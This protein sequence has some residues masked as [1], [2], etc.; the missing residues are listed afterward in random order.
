MWETIIWWEFR[1][2]PYNIIV[3]L[4]GIVTSILMLLTALVCE[5]V[6]GEPIGMPDPPIILVLGVVLYGIA[7]NICYTLGWVGELMAMKIWSD[8]IEAFG[9]AAFT[10]GTVGSVLLTLMP[11]LLTGAVATVSIVIHLAHAF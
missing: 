11:A 8:R 9:E 7:A 3:G 2:I 1:R 6:I 4:A 10:L 5:K